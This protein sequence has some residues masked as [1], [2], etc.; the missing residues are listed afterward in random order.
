MTRSQIEDVRSFPNTKCQH[1]KQEA[2]LVGLGAWTLPD[3]SSAATVRASSWMVLVP[4]SGGWFCLACGLVSLRAHL[5]A[6][7]GTCQ[8]RWP[9]ALAHL[10]LTLSLID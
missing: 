6:A 1:N 7:L 8:G 2:P 10:C 4:G 5:S 9:L 3:R